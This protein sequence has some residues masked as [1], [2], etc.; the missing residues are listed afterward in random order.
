SQAMHVIRN[1]LDA[2]RIALGRESRRIRYPAAVLVDIGAL[3]S[4]APVPEVVNIDVFVAKLL[5]ARILERARLGINLCCRG[6]FSD[7]APT[8]PAQ[9][10]LAL[11]AIVLRPRI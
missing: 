6:I 9:H 10:R 7:E 8:A 1:G 11:E 2:V 5:Q 4:G 3:R